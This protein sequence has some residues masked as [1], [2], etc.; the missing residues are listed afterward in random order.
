MKPILFNTEMVRAILDGRKTVTRRCIKPKY[1]NTHFEYRTDKYGT[2]FVEMQN[3][4]EGITYGVH[5]DGS[6]WRGM[7]GF[8]IPKPKY[9]VG[10][11]LYVR[12]A[13]SNYEER[14]PYYLYKANYEDGQE[15]FWFEQEQENWIDLPK[16][17]PSIHMPKEAARIFLRVTNVRIE[18]LR[19]I[20]TEDCFNEGALTSESYHNFDDDLMQPCVPFDFFERLWNSKI[21]KNELNQYGWDANPYVFAYEFEVI[22]KEEAMKE[23]EEG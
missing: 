4:E 17:K 1:S 7:K 10:D 5:E 16:W 3:D 23:S 11:T 12:E 13:W 18:R 9:E 15:G 19:E 8:L 6:C 20:T 2:Q 21:K 22:S 14:T